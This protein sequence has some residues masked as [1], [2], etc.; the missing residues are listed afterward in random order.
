MIYVHWIVLVVYLL[1]AIAALITI[2]LEN[3]QPAKTVAW[4][5]VLL[6]LPP[7][8]IILYFFFGQQRRKKRHKWQQSLDYFTHSSLSAAVKLRNIN[9]PD[10][11]KELIRLFINQ[12][13]ALPFKTNEVEIFTSGYEFFPVLLAEIAKAQHHIHL[14]SYIIE[15]DSLGNLIADALIEKAHQGIEVRLIYDDVGSWKVNNKFFERMRME[16]IE[17]H[18]FM[19]VRFPLFTRKV[20]YRNHRKL[21][22]ID[23][24][25][26]FI[27]GMN[28]ALRYVKGSNKQAW[29][30]THLMLRGAGTHGIQRAFVMDWFFVDQT[31]ISGQKYYPIT[32]YSEGSF[33]TQIVTSNPTS[34]SPEI[35][36]G[37]IKILL[38][39]K[40]YVYMQTPYFIPTE[41][42]LFAM[43]TAAIAGVDVRLMLPLHADKKI[44]Q[45]ASRSF[46]MEAARA[47]IKI[48]LHKNA[49]LHSK[50]LVADD[51]I[52]TIGSTNVDFRSF[53]N[54]FEANVFLYD[55]ETARKVKAIFLEDEHACLS[56]SKVKDITHPSFFQRLCESIV[57]LL[58]P[59]L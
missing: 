14:I 15:D 34:F 33:L 11:Q 59:L 9:L 6:F 41:P 26:G 8:G 49:F 30:D 54:N 3:R 55:T 53:E 20:N 31:L 39:A 17:V 47:G 40:R 57:R 28:I 22:V 1:F 35:E 12:S 32:P 10:K 44:V 5:L 16:G 4:V 21:C 27:G 50:L 36:Q 24:C 42:I 25:V 23:G 7:V 29:R 38:N 18:P 19:P 13:K 58:S 48:L 43:R 45:W 56:L 2:L 37:Y 52:A 51:C 46:V